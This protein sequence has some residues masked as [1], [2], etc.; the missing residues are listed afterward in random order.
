[1]LIISFTLSSSVEFDKCTISGD[2]HYRT[3]DGFSHHF[4][5]PYT[6]V[7][8]QSHNLETSLSPFVVRGK[9]LRRGGNRRVSLLDQ[10]YI[11]VYNVNVRFEQKKTVL[12]S[13]V[14]LSE[15]H[16]FSCLVLKTAYYIFSR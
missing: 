4:Q 3:F 8:A 7:L 13:S 16:L 1:M 10:M 14:S 11:D 15:Y 5:G 2:P 6:Y 12:V 9:N